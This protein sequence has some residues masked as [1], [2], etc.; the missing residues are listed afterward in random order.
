M[1][2]TQRV[3]TYL[4]T[5]PNFNGD[6]NK[7]MGTNCKN[8]RKSSIPII[9]IVT[10]AEY[11][12]MQID[13]SIQE[14]KHF[15]LKCVSLVKSYLNEY[16]VLEPLILALKT[17]LKNANLNDPYTG[18]LSSYG[19]ILMVVSFIQCKIDQ[20]SYHEEEEDLLGKTFYGFLGHYG[21]NLDFNKFVI[22]T[23]PINETN[24]A[25]V[26]NDTPLDFG[27]NSPELII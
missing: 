10:T 8:N 26:D 2:W 13:I 16:V 24:E 11:E 4:F 14:E 25:T 21:V 20:N 3:G 9:K 22:L 27:Q 23:Y 15:R 5:K 19:L 7:T 1:Q 6:K 18:G 17:I 12:R